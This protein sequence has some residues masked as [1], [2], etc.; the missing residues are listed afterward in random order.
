MP[1]TLGNDDPEVAAIIGRELERQRNNLILI[2]S[3]NYASIAVLQAQGCIFTNKYAEG[4]P[5]A[6]WYHGCEHADEI[7]SLAIS[8]AKALFEAEHANVQPHAG[9]PA[10][11]AAY[12][13]LLNPGD[14][15]LAMS[16]DQGGHLTHGGRSNFS[17]RFYNVVPYGV[18]Q[19]TETIDLD[20]V[21]ELALEHRPRLIV[22]GAS[23]YPRAIDFSPWRQI[24]DEVGAYL[25][26][27][28]AHIAGLVAGKVHPD[29]VPYCDVV[30][31]TTHKTL[32]GPRG[33]FILCKREHARAL[34]AAVFPGCQG[35]PLVHVTAAK[36]VCFQEASTPEFRDYAR[37]VVRNCQALARAL[38][39]EGLRLVSDGTDNHLLVI[40]VRPLGISG[41]QATDL[42]RDCNIIAN[43]NLIPY[44]TGAARN[45]SGVR[46]GTAAVTT[47]GLGEEEMRQVGSMIA[48]LLRSPGDEAIK[49]KAR[50]LVAELCSRFPLY[51]GL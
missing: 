39:D 44:D 9:A 5:G 2:A 29:P 15:M 21:R 30:T 18:S 46:L 1:P 3:E 43:K 6:R 45:P 19:Q 35:G 27:D 41:Q 42:L 26:A 24:A 32:R 22:V 50:D 23:A 4:Y 33:A 34:D 17:S 47:R 51:S 8:R 10:N 40:D 31:S 25:M 12:M 48:A 49:R 20:Q 38:S 7:E 11:L 16:V 28:M 13:A 37:Q 14:T 36:A